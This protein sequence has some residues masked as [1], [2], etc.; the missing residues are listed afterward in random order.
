MLSKLLTLILLIPLFSK[1]I[2]HFHNKER[3][4]QPREKKNMMS[5]LPLVYKTALHVRVPA[6]WLSTSCSTNHKLEPICI[7]FA[8]QT[9]PNYVR[10]CKNGIQHAPKQ[11][12]PPLPTMYSSF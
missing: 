3:G 5:P 2:G 4:S 6:K 1:F 11:C 12:M 8:M 9:L 7:F 10:I